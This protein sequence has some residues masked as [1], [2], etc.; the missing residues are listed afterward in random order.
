MDNLT[1]DVLAAEKAG[2][3]YGQYKALS[4]VPPKKPKRKPTA[5]PV[6]IDPKYQGTCKICGASFI[7]RN[8]NHSVC[9]DQCRL[10]A[11]TRYKME[12]YYA[13]RQSVN[14]AE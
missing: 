6:V 9:S 1:L 13:A 10:V 12:R 5:E 14:S 3:S 11:N 8:W 2:M 4:Y 7:K